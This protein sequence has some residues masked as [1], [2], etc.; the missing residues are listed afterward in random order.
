MDVPWELILDGLGQITV[1]AGEVR[2][3]FGGTGDKALQIFPPFAPEWQLI[4]LAQH[5]Q[6][7]CDL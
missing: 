5:H 6:V 3:E 1:L 7:G 4:A 2:A